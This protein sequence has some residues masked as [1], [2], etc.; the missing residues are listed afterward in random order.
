[1][2][3]IWQILKQQGWGRLSAGVGHQPPR[4]WQRLFT[5]YPH[6]TAPA[7]ANPK[8]RLIIGTPH[9]ELSFF[10]PERRNINFSRDRKAI[11]RHCVNYH[12][13]RWNIL[14]WCNEQPTNK[15]QLGKF[16]IC[17]C[18]IIQALFCGPIE[19]SKK[20]GQDFHT[21]GG[22]VALIGTIFSFFI[23]F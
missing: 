8:K 6:T 3:I 17:C 9:R 5:K 18:A 15:D 22:E 12:S 4:H 10:R 11:T 20:S 16:Y 1:M 14:V 2:K 13:P 21:G 19:T 23:A 7:A